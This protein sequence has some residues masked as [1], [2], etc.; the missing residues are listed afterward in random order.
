MFQ[1]TYKNNRENHPTVQIGW[2]G[3]E[4]ARRCTEAWDTMRR[5]H[6]P[7]VRPAGYS[8]RRIVKGHRERVGVPNSHEHARKAYRR[9]IFAVADRL[10]EGKV[11]VV[12]VDSLPLQCH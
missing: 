6:V 12:R 9:A 3:A 5:L 1:R 7:G 2:I 8:W 10:N 11:P 4:V